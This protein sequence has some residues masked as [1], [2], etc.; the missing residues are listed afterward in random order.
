MLAPLQSG[1]LASPL[2]AVFALTV[3]ESLLG[4][5]ISAGGYGLLYGAERG[6]YGGMGATGLPVW[7][8]FVFCNVLAVS[9]LCALRFGR[10]DRTRA[11]SELGYAALAIPA[12]Q[13]V[14]FGLVAVVAGWS[15]LWANLI[16]CSLFALLPAHFFASAIAT[17]RGFW[18]ADSRGDLV[19]LPCFF[20][21]YWLVSRLIASTAPGF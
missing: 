6:L 15:D 17:A 5:A 9:A 14:A 13:T 19:A 11:I 3:G 2:R 7:T 12:A 21:W 10:R 20:A 4:F 1:E 8:P 18:R 16:A